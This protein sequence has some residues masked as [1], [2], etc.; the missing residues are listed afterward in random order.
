MFFDSRE[1][2]LSSAGE[3]KMVFPRWEI[4]NKLIS[5][6][7]IKRDIGSVEIGPRF[8]ESVTQ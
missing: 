4:A 7:P 6:I 2:D 3:I 8:R 1:S 5:F